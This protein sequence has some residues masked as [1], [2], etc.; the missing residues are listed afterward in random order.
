[1]V[2]RPLGYANVAIEGHPIAGFPVAVNRIDGV[3][4]MKLLEDVR[5]PA[6]PQAKVGPELSEA[7]S[8]LC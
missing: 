1:V 5:H 4:A 2:L 8:K 6:N 3:F 7:F